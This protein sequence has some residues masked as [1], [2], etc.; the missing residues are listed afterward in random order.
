VTRGP[1]AI[2]IA[3]GVFLAA[4]LLALG[5][6][7]EAVVDTAVY[8]TTARHRFEQERRD[9]AA[10]AR[11]LGPGGI[12]G[13][14]KI[15]RVG[16]SAVVVQGD[17][18]L[19]LRRAVGHLPGS[20]LP[21]QPGNVVLAGHRDTFFQSLRQV[22]VGDLIAMET[23]G[24]EFEY[25]VESTTVVSPGHVEVLEPT[26]RPTLTLIT[27]YPFGYLG[28]APE[29]FIVRARETRRSAAPAVVERASTRRP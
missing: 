6:V 27:C 20:A 10:P 18:A 29:R 22:R 11:V 15:A 3:A 25:R 19:I 14:V 16:L 13:E 9:P 5:Y 28:A 4:G 24:G 26:P 17:S 2:R 12:V 7:A 8:Q 21:G 23:S 1:R